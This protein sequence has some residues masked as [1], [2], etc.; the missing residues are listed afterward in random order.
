MVK[1]SGK[2]IVGFIAVSLFFFI[3]SCGD[4]SV[5]APQDFV[6]GTITYIDTLFNFS[7]GYYAVSIFGDNANPFSHQPVR[8]DSVA[9]NTTSKTSYY[10][11]EGLA[12][13]SYFI[14]CTWV[15]RSNGVVT[16][17]GSYG[18]NENPMCSNPTKIILPNYAGTGQLDFRSKTH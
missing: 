1:T 7:G 4:E 15:N 16:I 11:V 17:L 5:N 14:G 12:A 8:S 2:T 10:R 6:S 3:S 9:V 13:G 18:C